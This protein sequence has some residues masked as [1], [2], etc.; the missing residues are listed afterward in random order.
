MPEDYATLGGA[1]PLTRIA[2]PVQSATRRADAGFHA[3]LL[4]AGYN[5]VFVDLETADD[6]LLAGY[7]AAVF[8]SRGYLDLGSFGK[9][10]V[11]TLRGGTLVTFPEPVSRDQDG[12]PLRTAFLWPLPPVGRHALGRARLWSQS[13]RRWVVQRLLAA[14]GRFSSIPDA[15]HGHGPLD[16]ASTSRRALARGESLTSQDGSIVRGDLAVFDY[17]E[18]GDRRHLVDVLLRRGRTPVAYRAQV[19]SGTSTVV[20]THLAGLYSAGG[21]QTYTLEER[22]SLRRFAVSLFEPVVRRHL[23]PEGS[24]EVE[25]IAR[26]SPDGGCLLFVVNRLPP[27][28]GT[29]SL[30][31]PAALN[32][33]AEFTA[34]VQ[35]S[36]YGSQAAAT[37]DG[38]HLSLAAGDVVVLRLR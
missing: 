28:D 26:L 14:A 35:F 33:G 8:P 22:R 17:Q 3:L 31:E 38:V 7:P 9:L 23:V 24:L 20:G 37:A 12:A 11:F 29:I 10:V 30:P 19:R 6:A 5:P 16:A 36:A 15:L 34:T 32:L 1:G 18:P 21:Y 2:D 13:L 25:T 4:T 27:Q